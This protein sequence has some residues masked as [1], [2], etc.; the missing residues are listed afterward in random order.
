VKT[1]GVPDDVV[2][3]IDFLKNFNVPRKVMLDLPPAEILSLMLLLTQIMIGFSKSYMKY[4]S[5]S[6]SKFTGAKPAAT[7][8]D[9]K[10]GMTEDEL[11][12]SSETKEVVDGARDL[13]QYPDPENYF[14]YVY[15]IETMGKTGD[16]EG[17]NNRLKSNS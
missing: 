11:L 3:D 5:N 14:R 12:P 6:V 10:N 7:A 1:V 4:K 16:G 15:L 9:V 2:K 8:F 17:P 13:L